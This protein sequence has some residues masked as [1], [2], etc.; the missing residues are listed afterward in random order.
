MPG[1]RPRRPRIAAF[2]A[3]ELLLVCSLLAILIL[4]AI[5]ATKSIM[6]SSQM[7]KSGAN[8]R[9]MS[10]ALT[11][12]MGDRQ[13]RLPEG[14]HLCTIPGYS[15]SVAGNAPGIGLYW[16]NALAYYLEGP[17]YYPSR[18]RQPVPPKWLQCPARPFNEFKLG[19]SGYAVSVGYGW[20]WSFLGYRPGNPESSSGWGS[21]ITEVT[22]PAQTIAIGTNG[23]SRAADNQQ[24][25]CLYVAKGVYST[26]FNGAGLFLFLDGHLERL[27]Y[28]QA[29]ADN[30]WLY[31]KIKPQR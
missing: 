26:R 11:Q 21:R 24:N 19:P 12:Y 18:A 30:R 15:G 6:L 25:V 4:M 14:S 31:Q 3:V 28:A 2:S 23:E 7:S 9:Q 13:G 27:T 10:S 17:E 29:D 1:L 8:L 5:P 20:N 22:D 16:F